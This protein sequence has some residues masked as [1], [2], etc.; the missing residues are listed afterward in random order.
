ML[1]QQGRNPRTA[2]NL[3]IAV[4]MF[5]GAATLEALTRAGRTASRMAHLHGPAKEVPVAFGEHFSAL[6]LSQNAKTLSMS[7]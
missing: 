3:V 5:P 4:K 2:S 6:G 1:S 7:P